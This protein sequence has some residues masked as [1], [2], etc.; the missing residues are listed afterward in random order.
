MLRSSA[1]TA[2]GLKGAQLFRKSN[3]KP[4]LIIEPF[5]AICGLNCINLQMELV[6][7]ELAAGTKPISDRHRHQKCYEYAPLHSISLSAR[8]KV[9]G[10][11]DA[12]GLR[13]DAGFG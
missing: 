4:P 7:Q 2:I 6:R 13:G 12:Q 1:A 3:A 10:K 8:A 9:E 5:D 11:G